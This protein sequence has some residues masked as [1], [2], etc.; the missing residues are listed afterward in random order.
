MLTDSLYRHQ[1]T[2]LRVLIFCFLLALPLLAQAVTEPADLPDIGSPA[3]SVFSSLEEEQIGRMVLQQLRESG[4][5]LSDPEVEEYI[6]NLGQSL[7]ANANAGD[8][9]FEFFVVNDTKINAFA[10][11]GGYIGVNLGLILATDNE[12][13]IAGVLAHEIA[14]VTQ[15]H[16]ERRIF[17]QRGVSLAA[18]AAIIAAVIIGSSSNASAQTMQGGIMAVQGLAIQNQINY[19]R[20]NEYEADR[21]GIGTLARSGFDPYGMPSFFA[22]LGSTNSRAP[23][24]V[25]EFLQ[26]HPSSS[27]RV[28]ESSNRAMKYP[29]VDHVNGVS[30]RL[31]QERLR[32]R[33]FKSANEAVNYYRNTAYLQAVPPDPAWVYGSALALMRAGKSSQAADMFRELL[34]DNENIIDLHS[35]LG[36]ALMADGRTDDS[37]AVFQRAAALFPRNVPL[38]VRYSQ[39]LILAEQPDQA[40]EILLDLLNNISPTPDQ[41]RLIAMAASE[42]GELAEAHYYMSEYFILNGLLPQAIQQ[43]DL[44]LKLPGLSAIQHARFIARRDELA[45]YLPK[46]EKKRSIVKR[47]RGRHLGLR[48]SASNPRPS[49]SD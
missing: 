35:A 38:T 12:S 9:D 2:V 3:D 13:E 20:A 45:E 46:E 28:A 8:E 10:L 1:D 40:H 29:V 22:K 6:Q 33:S 21:I 30:Y 11:P 5:L 19:T 39:A 27:A 49:L 32:V 17:D 41:A 23:D 36:Q 18:T 7:V 37:L 42:A 26:T 34:R 31:V 48:Q 44:A 25:P 14:H 16:I 43:L 4:Q 15:N 24:S 47:D